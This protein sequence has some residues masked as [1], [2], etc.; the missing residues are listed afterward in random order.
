MIFSLDFTDDEFAEVIRRFVEA[1]QQM[2]ADG[3]WDGPREENRQIRRSML[4][5]FI[6][7]RLGRSAA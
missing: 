6:R 1:G 4:R 2:K 3:W 7:T 5:E